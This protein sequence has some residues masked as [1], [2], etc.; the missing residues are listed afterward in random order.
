MSAGLENQE[1]ECDVHFEHDGGALIGHG[2]QPRERLGLRWREQLF[3]AFDRTSFGVGSN[4]LDG[5]M[6]TSDLRFDLVPRDPS[7]G[8]FGRESGHLDLFGARVALIE[9]FSGHGRQAYGDP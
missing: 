7:L 6:V 9:R 3:D 4:A 5:L 1:T 8:L 2:S